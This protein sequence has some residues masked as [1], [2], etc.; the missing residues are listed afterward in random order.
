MTTPATSFPESPVLRAVVARSEWGHYSA[1]LT[2]PDGRSQTLTGDQLD[3]VRAAVIDAARAYLANDVGHSGRLHVRDPD[4]HWALGVPHDG[5]ELLELPTPPAAPPLPTPRPPARE[6]VLPSRPAVPSRGR[7]VRNPAPKRERASSRRVLALAALAAA[8]LA[9]AG[10][11]QAMRGS[12]RATPA[13]AINSTGAHT[14][15]HTTATVAVHTTATTPAA[16]T[17]ATVPARKSTAPTRPVPPPR[18]RRATVKPKAQAKAMP[19]AKA[20]HA[21]V[22][23]HST[24]VATA[25]AAPASVS[26]APAS[27][28]AA[29]AS[30]SAAPMSVPSTPTYVPPVAPTTCY[31]GEPGC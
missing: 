24:A 26:A 30:V 2:L 27:V 8:V 16:Q 13:A 28:S 25:P 12:S 9:V 14:V 31:P 15:A 3:G 17:T 19:H 1:T 7:P 23:H 20:T 4:G 22:A 29:A 21:P 10:I 11:A 6:V 5:G 18:A